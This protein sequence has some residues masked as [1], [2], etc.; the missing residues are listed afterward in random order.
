MPALRNEI[1]SL[2][3]EFLMK[4]VREATTQNKSERQQRKKGQKHVDEGRG[5]G[6]ME[7]GEGEAGR[8][9]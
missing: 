1:L 2:P 6:G 3:A 9:D 8:R 5:W 7:K 4:N